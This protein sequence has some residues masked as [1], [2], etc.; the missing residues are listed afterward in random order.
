MH[1]LAAAKLRGEKS[2]KA[3]FVDP[4]LRGET[5]PG[6]ASRLVPT[7]PWAGIAGIGA[8]TVAIL[9]N[10]SADNIRSFEKRLGR[11]G[12]HESFGNARGPLLRVH[13][14]HRSADE[15]VILVLAHQVS[16][17]SWSMRTLVGRG[18]RVTRLCP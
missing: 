3:R 8:S 11:D 15:T 10:R 16:T 14:Y 12:M 17:D 9:R 4:Y 13:L 1:R 7:G 18:P 6:I 2:I 5:Y